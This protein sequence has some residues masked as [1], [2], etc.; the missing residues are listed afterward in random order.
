MYYI[1]PKQI[2][3]SWLLSSEQYFSYIHGL[4]YGIW[5]EE[6][7]AIKDMWY[8]RQAWIFLST[9]TLIVISCCKSTLMWRERNNHPT[10]DTNLC[11]V[12]AHRRANKESWRWPKREINLIVCPFV[13]FLLVIVLSALLRFTDSDY[14]FGIFKLFLVYKNTYNRDKYNH[15]DK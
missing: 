1:S 15:Q 4:V 8:N 11:C 7:K 14:I 5:R 6:L 12:H 3:Y 9:P 13:L 2:C 10:P